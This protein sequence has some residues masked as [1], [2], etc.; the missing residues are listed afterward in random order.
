ML[1]SA[2][3]DPK[4]WKGLIKGTKWFQTYRGGVKKF[5]AALAQEHSSATLV[6][7][8]IHVSLA[9]RGLRTHHA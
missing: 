5:L 8:C 7:I 2:G 1:Q 4:V 9:S 3:Q 6:V